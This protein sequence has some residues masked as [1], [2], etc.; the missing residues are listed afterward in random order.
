MTKY[1]YAGK[2]MAFFDWLFWLAFFLALDTKSFLSPSSSS[3]L[4]KIFS[5]VIISYISSS[6]FL[7]SCF[8]FRFFDREKNIRACPFSLSFISFHFIF[9]EYRARIFFTKLHYFL[10]FFLVNRNTFFSSFFS[11]SKFPFLICNGREIL[12]VD[13][14]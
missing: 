13:I 12:G 1:I 11:L 5:I 4:Y 9:F 7:L 10:M 2:H 3:S 14:R 6:Y 8:F